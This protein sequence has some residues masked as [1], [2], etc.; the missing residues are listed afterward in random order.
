[1][2]TDLKLIFRYCKNLGIRK[3][4]WL[5]LK[6]ELLKK[7][8]FRMSGYPAPL[9]LRPATTDIKVF[10]EVFLFGVYSFKTNINARV[11]FDAGANVGLSS[12]FFANRFPSAT[13]YA[14]EP[15]VSNFKMLRQNIAGYG[16]IRPL[17]T[18]LWS[19][20]TILKITDSLENQ[21]AF[22]VQECQQDE[23]GSF[24]ALSITTLMQQHRIECIDILKMDIE[25][26]ERELFSENFD[27]WVSRTK[28]MIVELHDWIK[29][30]CSSSFFSAIAR[31]NIK[32]T[33]HE[34]ML[35]IEFNH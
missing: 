25:G 22:T 17:Q 33:V 34:G 20:D 27:Y 12:V 28:L 18:A 5:F 6:V 32:T 19:S 8:R 29:P 14:I 26:A 30:G 4:L 16:N 9:Q 23:E 10:R 7:S 21:W 35:L 15:E 13:I 2:E 11:I 24:P 31:Y 3:G 1:M